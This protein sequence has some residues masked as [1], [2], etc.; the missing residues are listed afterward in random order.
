MGA[1]QHMVRWLSMKRLNRTTVRH[2]FRQGWERM[3]LVP[4]GI[5]PLQLVKG[6]GRKTG[7]AGQ[8]GWV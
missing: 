4:L 8:E 2:L 5:A 7:R 1:R 6:I 3:A